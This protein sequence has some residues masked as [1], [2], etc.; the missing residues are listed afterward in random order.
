M[1]NNTSRGIFIPVTSS[2]IGH[3]RRKTKSIVGHRSAS[4]N[5]IQYYV[6]GHES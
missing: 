3:F 4:P 1:V 6:F 5:Y 2:V